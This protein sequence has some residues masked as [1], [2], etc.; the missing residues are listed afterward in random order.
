MVDFNDKDWHMTDL[1]SRQKDKTV[2]LRGGKKIL[3]KSP[4]FGLD[5]KTY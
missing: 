5:I 1:T 4:R 3:V 2:T